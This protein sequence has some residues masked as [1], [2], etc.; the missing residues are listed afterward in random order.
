MDGAAQGISPRFDFRLRVG[1]ACRAVLRPVRSAGPPPP[2]LRLVPPE[3][4]RHRERA[5]EAH[6]SIAGPRSCRGRAVATAYRSDRKAFDCRAL[7]VAGLIAV[8]CLT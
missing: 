4:A 3:A 7:R 8:R 5:Q 1:T 2:P 6:G